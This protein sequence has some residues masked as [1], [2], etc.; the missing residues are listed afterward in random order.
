MNRIVI[1]YLLIITLFFMSAFA[2]MGEERTF[3]VYCKDLQAAAYYADALS[4]DD[5]SD[6]NM[7]LDAELC[8]FFT[9]EARGEVTQ[10]FVLGDTGYVAEGI[11]FSNGEKV[12]TV[13]P[14]TF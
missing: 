14:E 7:I 4:H 9:F 6:L 3:R 1:F 8:Q 5:A 13:S 12:L 2:V 11:D 10:T